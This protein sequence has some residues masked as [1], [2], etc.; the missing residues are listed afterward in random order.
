MNKQVDTEPKEECETRR[1]DLK[2]LIGQLSELRYQMQRDRPIANLQWGSD[3]KYW[4]QVVEVYTNKNGKPPSWFSA[5]WLFVECFMYRKISDVVRTSACFK[6][7]DPFKTQK[8]DSY[9][10]YQKPSA[11]LAK[12]VN[13]ITS[14]DIGEDDIQHKFLH[15]LLI[16]LWGN[17]T[18][19][20]MVATQD[21]YNATQD[22]TAHDVD[23]TQEV[24]RL[25]G[26]VLSNH[27]NE[28]YE[29]I[30]SR[31]C[32][33]IDFV[34][35]NAGFE[36]FTDLCFA[37]FLVHFGFAKTIV[38]HCKQLPWFVSDASMVDF[39]WLLDQLNCHD[40]SDLL[41]LGKK[42]KKRVAEG[43]WVVVDHMFWTLPHDYAQMK[44][45]APDLYQELSKSSLVFFK[46]DLNYRKLVS[47]RNWP[48][49]APFAEVLQG[50]SPTNLCALRTLKAD[51]VGGLPEGAAKMA[52]TKDKNWLVSGQF[53][54]IQCYHL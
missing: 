47:D 7:F 15:M 49:T 51:L 46:G 3:R 44:S 4:E 45:T 20:S 17:K 11:S 10:Q 5:S 43:S 42:W 13:F 16:S 25:L 48:Y 14:K 6:D 24:E 35:D 28:V 30:K 9:F 50:F 38:F 27:S 34:L 26:N 18:D 32:S 2:S 37:E 36:L 39:M 41:A 33:R 8:M 22:V 40:S 52:A 53:G 31:A 29:V 21:D 19:L 23:T 12:L 1:E 54:V